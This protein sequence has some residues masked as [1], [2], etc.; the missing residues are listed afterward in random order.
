MPAYLGVSLELGNVWQSRDAIRLRGAHLDG[1]I[2]L[3][4]DTFLG[5]IYL[6]GGLDE[7]GGNAFYLLLGRAF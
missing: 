7:D 6:A 1:A 3:G 2:F 5:P 4:L